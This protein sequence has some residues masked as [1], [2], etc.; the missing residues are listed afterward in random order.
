MLT[1]APLSTRRTGFGGVVESLRISNQVGS[2]P[3]DNARAGC[4][5]SHLTAQA[6]VAKLAI[7]CVHVN[8]RDHAST[9]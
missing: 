9:G 6:F 7:V 2:N 3:I 4:P 1:H 8:M 5:C